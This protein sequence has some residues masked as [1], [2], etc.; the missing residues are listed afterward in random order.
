[1]RK[2][3]NG[4]PHIFPECRA[5]RVNFQ[6]GLVAIHLR[7]QIPRV[8]ELLAQAKKHLLRTIC[9]IKTDQCRI[10]TS[11]KGHPLL[12]DLGAATQ[13]AWPDVLTPNQGIRV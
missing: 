4:R 11:S 9:V 12:I 6:E 10:M 13:A 7:N 8:A 3:I 2:I 5:H 1:M